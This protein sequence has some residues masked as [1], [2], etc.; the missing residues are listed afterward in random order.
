MRDLVTGNNKNHVYMKDRRK[1]LL[2][3]LYLVLNLL[4]LF[5]G[6]PRYEVS[7]DFMMELIASGTYGI[8][9]GHIMFSNTIYGSIIAGLYSLLPAVNWYYVIQTIVTLISGIVMICILVDNTKD[10]IN[11]FI[12]TVLF[13]LFSSQ[14]LFVLPQFT[15]TAA[16][17][18]VSGGLLFIRSVFEH[19]KSGMIIG[20]VLGAI[21]SMIRYM[22][23]LIAGPFLVIFFF[24]LLS[25]DDLENFRY[26]LLHKVLPVLLAVVILLGLHGLQSL[27]YGENG[28]R[29]YQDFSN[30][31]ASVVDY[32]MP[33][34]SEIKELLEKAQIS[35][36]DYSMIRNWMFDDIEVFSQDKMQDLK[37]IIT[38]YRN[39]HRKSILSALASIYRRGQISYPIAIG[40]MIAGILCIISNRN[41]WCIPVVCML[42]ISFYFIHF[43]VQGRMVYRIEFACYI[44]A[45]TLILM[46]YRDIRIGKTFQMIIAG[47]FLLAICLNYGK[48]AFPDKTDTMSGDEYREYIDSTFYYSWDYDSDKY[49]KVVSCGDIRPDFLEEVKK[50][51]DNVYL[52]EFPTCI[53]T[54]Y[55][56]FRISDSPVVV[57]P[58]NVVYLGGVTAYHPTMNRL[59]D[60][61]NYESWLDSLLED[62]VFF[63][64]NKMQDCLLVYFREH[65]YAEVSCE[66][67][68]E[69]DGYK[70]WKYHKD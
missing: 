56:D 49:I 69:L 29:L 14:D 21:G 46:Q 20:L 17:A 25:R 6:N 58:E 65:G 36:N 12:L 7:D 45:F 32:P 23:L 18:V 33:D 37:T 24:S 57:F 40:C 44:S 19:K 42:L 63:V 51:K 8:P 50:E 59:L 31:R 1:L 26:L 43:A 66:L 61:R 70:I 53:Q 10:L 15:K 54:F 22:A 64:G 62:N 68:K 38:D 52:M 48:Y 28:Y 2:V 16:I 30:T 47:L 34:Y 27:T 67:Y 9:D 3:L 35:E 13:S 4:L 11:G 55:Y 5:F 41:R 60:N 39:A